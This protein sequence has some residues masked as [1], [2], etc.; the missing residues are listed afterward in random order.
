ME[1]V[2]V[3]AVR[4]SSFVLSGTTLTIVSVIAVALVSFAVVTGLKYFRNRTLH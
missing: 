4:D 3:A 1:T 2:T